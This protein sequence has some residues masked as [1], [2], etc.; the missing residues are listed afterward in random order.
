[1][2][3]KKNKSMVFDSDYFRYVMASNKVTTQHLSYLLEVSRNHMDKKIKKG[4]FDIDEARI[5]I[6]LFR[7]S[8]DE[9]FKFKGE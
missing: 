6:E 5:L 8:F 1:M 3:L 7:L 2:K 4:I 9:V